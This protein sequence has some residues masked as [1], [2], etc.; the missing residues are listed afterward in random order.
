[1]FP[2]M[3]GKLQDMQQKLEATKANF[4]NVEIEAEAGDGAVK[5]LV[6]AN[7]KVKNIS[8]DPSIVDP[9]DVEQIEDLLMV[10]MNRAMEKAS[11]RAEQ[12][13]KQVYDQVMPGM[14]NIPGLD[15]LLG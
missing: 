10:A 9:N 8:I 12:D 15:G 4:D 7:H 1:M 13:V 14:G 6:S 5:V 3:F 2:D 11:Q